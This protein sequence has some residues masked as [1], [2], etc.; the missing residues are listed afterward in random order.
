MPTTDQKPADF[1][2]IRTTPPPV[3]GD[4]TLDRV[5]RLGERVAGFLNHSLS[6]VLFACASA[7]QDANM[8]Q[9]AAWLFRRFHELEGG[10]DTD[11]PLPDVINLNRPLLNLFVPATEEDRAALYEVTGLN[12]LTADEFEYWKGI[13]ELYGTALSIML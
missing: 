7:C 13:V 4:S 9:E 2:I 10:D 8:K 12:A 11:A 5:G 6:D 3:F 1:Q